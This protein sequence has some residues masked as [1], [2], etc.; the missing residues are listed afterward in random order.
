M[1]CGSKPLVPP[2]ALVQELRC[3]ENYVYEKGVIRDGARGK[4]NGDIATAPY[5]YD[6]NRDW[7][8]ID[9]VP[10]SQN[11]WEVLQYDGGRSIGLGTSWTDYETAVGGGR[12]QSPLPHPRVRVVRGER[13]S[14][15]ARK[16]H[17][18]RAVTLKRL[19]LETHIVTYG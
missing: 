9:V 18:R 8:T 17:P 19:H 1:I 5:D 7:D 12:H 2:P 11:D 13:V 10:E 14:S 4:H 3:A 6:F 15:M 16:R